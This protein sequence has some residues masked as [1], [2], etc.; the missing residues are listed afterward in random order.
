[1]S[2]EPG[3]AAPGRDAT[4]TASRSSCAPGRGRSRASI[5]SFWSASSASDF[6]YSPVSSWWRSIRRAG[7]LPL[8]PTELYNVDNKPK[9]DG[10]ARLPAT[11]E[12]VGSSRRMRP[13]GRKCDRSCSVPDLDTERDRTPSRATARQAG[14]RVGTVLPLVN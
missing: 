2:S 10:L 13:K 1:M 4:T 3:P 14:A 6:C 11:Y 7:A 9:S 12:G 5:A 8:L